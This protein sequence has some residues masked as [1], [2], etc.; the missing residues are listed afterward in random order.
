MV[1]GMG[2]VDIFWFTTQLPNFSTALFFE[3]CLS[4]Y[5]PP[6]GLLGCYIPLVQEGPCWQVSLFATVLRPLCPP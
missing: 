5:F 2:S 6:P 1:S 3:A 4:G